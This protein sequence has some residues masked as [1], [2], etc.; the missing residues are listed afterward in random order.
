MKKLSYWILVVGFVIL[1][2]R[3][4][5]M[6]MEKTPKALELTRDIDKINNKKVHC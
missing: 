4:Q 3:E 2:V 5:R 1:S 6:I